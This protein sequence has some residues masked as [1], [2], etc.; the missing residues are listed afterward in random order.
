MCFLPHA[1]LLIIYMSSVIIRRLTLCLET[2]RAVKGSSPD[3]TLG[4]VEAILEQAEDP[5]DLSDPVMVLAFWIMLV[6]K[7]Q[8]CVSCNSK[9]G[10]LHYLQM[11]VP[12]DTLRN[13]CAKMAKKT[14]DTATGTYAAVVAQALS[15]I[16]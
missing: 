3:V 2:R 7:H 14:P 8:N 1:L 16:P 4:D 11:V 9:N 12:A 6:G 5:L 13:R 10:C 15:T